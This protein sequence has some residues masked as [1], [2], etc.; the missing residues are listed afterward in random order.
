M[1]N[2]TFRKEDVIGIEPKH[3]TYVKAQ[4]GTNHDLLVAKEMVHLKDGRRIPNLRMKEDYQRPFWV[5]Q[6]G[7]RNHRDKKDYEYVSNC[8]KYT[9]TQIEL[10][11]RIAK[12][13]NDFSSGPNPPI[14]RLA[15]SPYLYGA[16]VSSAC[17]FKAD[18]RQK[19]PDLISFNKV[20][21]G[22]I[23]TNVHS[24][25]G[26]IICMSATCRENATLVY[27]KSWIGDIH[28]PVGQTHAKAKEYIGD[29]LESRNT[30]LEVLVV[31]NPSDIVITVLERLHQWQPEFFTFWNMDY[32][33]TRMI[34]ALED[35]AIDPAKVFSDPRVP[36]KYR[37]CYYRRGPAQKVTASGKTMSINIEDRWNWL[38]HPASFQT[39]D[40]M[41]V[42]RIL[43]VANGKDSSYA[44]DYILDKE[45]SF[46]FK[47]TV[48]T[49]ED[50]DKF[51]DEVREKL[52]SNPG[53]T[54]SFTINKVPVEPEAIR[55][56]QI[57]DKLAVAADF[58]KL[59]F[60]ATSHLSGL[61]WHE[62]MQ[63]KYKIEYGIYNVFD[64]IALELLDEKTNDLASSIS[65]FAKNSDYKNFN[66]NPKRLCD[67]MHFWYLNRDPACVIGTSSDEP[68]DELD[69]HVIGHDDWIVTLPSYM[70]GPT[71]LKCVKEFP[72]YKTLVFAHV[73][74]LDIVSTYP[75][76]S[77]LLN[78]A[79]ET[80]VMEFSRMEGV[81]EHHRREVG[82]NLTGGRV[83]AVE[84]CEKILGAPTL[85]QLLADFET[86]TGKKS[87][88]LGSGDTKS[89]P[90][91][92]DVSLL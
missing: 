70:A 17:L 20:A 81:T 65:M 33:V 24:K 89:Q 45:L 72:D 13:L 53:S 51:L 71:G 90:E 88:G 41:P 14:K 18:Y 3:I 49:P 35:A 9:S 40:S 19:W 43:R 62:V 77:Q 34:A 1:S 54:P 26:E 42:Y 50:I 52:R 27:L 67:D 66:S 7:R 58:G 60:D 69:K 37:Y 30:K 56:A 47:Q 44:L 39:I 15:R 91:A 55:Q 73:A 16:D 64:S 59:K 36:D 32:D 78:I 8:Q 79:R 83:N 92:T 63:E 87:G 86:H 31:D 25:D 85:D 46:K 28:D 11:R 21:A 57:G 10:P 82:V 22:D 75:N 29:V 4:D 76:V 2:E 6:P 12:T 23:E 48:E 80:C 84:I 68:V 5:T 38:T 61:R 74:D